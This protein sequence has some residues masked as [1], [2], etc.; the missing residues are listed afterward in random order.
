MAPP[1][2]KSTLPDSL[3]AHPAALRTLSRLVAAGAI[4]IS[5]KPQAWYKH[6]QHFQAFAT[7]HPEIFRKR[8]RKLVTEKYSVPPKKAMLFY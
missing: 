2:R 6:P 3:A 7:I 4:K 5:D 1:K 8:F